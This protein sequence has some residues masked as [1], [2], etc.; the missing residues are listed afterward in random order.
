MKAKAWDLLI[1]TSLIA[2]VCL[3]QILFIFRKRLVKQ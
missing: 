1:Q 3:S 2:T